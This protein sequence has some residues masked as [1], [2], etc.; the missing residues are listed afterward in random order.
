MM[1]PSRNARSSF[2]RMFKISYYG[3]VENIPFVVSPIDID[4]PVMSMADIRAARVTAVSGG[5][6]LRDLSAHGLRTAKLRRALAPD[7][8]RASTRA[9]I[10]DEVP[11]QP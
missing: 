8:G 1:T 4:D 7:R 10:A 9:T 5:A 11:V 2:I 6:G 3:S